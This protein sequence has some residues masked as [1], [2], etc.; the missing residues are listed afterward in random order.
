MN[1]LIVLFSLLFA[2]VITFTGCKEDTS[3]D[4]GDTAISPVGYMP[5]QTGNYYVYS[6][7][8]VGSVPT[9][10]LGERRTG[11]AGKQT[12]KGTEYI[13]QA[14]TTVLGGFATF[15]QSFIR[16]TENGVYYYVDTTG[17]GDV[18]PDSLKSFLTID[19]EVVLLSKPVNV[20]RTW[21]AFRLVFFNIAV[22]DMQALYAGEETLT[23]NL[24]G[25]D[26]SIKTLRVEYTLK[27]SV[28]AGFGLDSLNQT[29]KMNAWYAD[30]IGIVKLNGDSGIIN[31]LTGAGIDLETE[32]YKILYTLRS[33]ALKP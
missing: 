5:T 33:Y 15:S 17:L 29:L 8:T 10:S 25:K 1:R 27:V 19:P 21:T 18:L 20:G 23:L 30:K 2:M 32:S 9:F 16:A 11:F 14:D 26:E 24:N 4:P 13:T 28:P 3:T 6:I 31:F 7:D 22:I 12:K